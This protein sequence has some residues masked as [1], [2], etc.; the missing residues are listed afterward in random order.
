VRFLELTDREWLQLLGWIAPHL[1]RAITHYLQLLETAGQEVSLGVSLERV[2]RALDRSYVIPVLPDPY[3][4]AA[5]RRRLELSLSRVAPTSQEQNGWQRTF[6][7]LAELLA[8]A[9]RFGELCIL[10]DGVDAY[11]P[12]IAPLDQVGAWLTDVLQLAGNV[13]GSAISVKCFVPHLVEPFVRRRLHLLER[14]VT[15]ESLSWT[16]PELAKLLRTR[17]TVATAGR[18]DS[19]DALSDPSLREIE[20]EIAAVV[21]PLP[22]EAIYLA[23]QLLRSHVERR[24]RGSPQLGI[25]DLNDAIEPYQRFPWIS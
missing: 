24:A 19:L 7:G 3:T 25:Q 17:I 15:L 23:G 21:Q 9:L 18:F 16:P 4:L 1:P 22:R 12:E 13:A 2:R 10:M 20:A 14:P 5:V 6:L 8:R 11:A